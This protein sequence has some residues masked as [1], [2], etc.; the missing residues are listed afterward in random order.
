M[1]NFKPL[2]SFYTDKNLISKGDKLATENHNQQNGA[3]SHGHFG[4][5][6]IFFVLLWVDLNTHS[7]SKYAIVYLKTKL[8][9]QP[10][11]YY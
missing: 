1:L 4:C 3:K 9:L 2:I 5:H 7:Y 6:A 10:T 11:A 8:K